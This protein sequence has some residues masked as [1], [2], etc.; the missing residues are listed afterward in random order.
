M[1]ITPTPDKEIHNQI[2][3]LP[4]LVSFSLR[5]NELIV[6]QNEDFGMISWEYVFQSDNS[7]VMLKVDFTSFKKGKVTCQC[8]LSRNGMEYFLFDNYLK[9]LRN[10]ELLNL[11]QTISENMDSPL[12]VKSFLEIL[13]LH[14]ETGLKKVVTGQEWIEVPFDWERVGR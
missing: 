8:L 11:K 5:L 3:A 2:I 12:F 6:S 10:D 1:N 4:D 13:V 7:S 9:F 14:L